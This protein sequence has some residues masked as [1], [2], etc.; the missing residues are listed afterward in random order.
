MRFYCHIHKRSFSAPTSSPIECE[1]GGHLLGSAPGD[2]DGSD[3]WEYCCD[4]QNFWLISPDGPGFEQCPVCERRTAARYFCNHCNTITVETELPQR[5][6]AVFLSLQKLPVPA[7]PGCQRSQTDHPTEHTCKAYDGSLSTL[8]NKCPFCHEAIA[9]LPAF[10]MSVS[11]FVGQSKDRLIEVNLDPDTC[12]FIRRPGGEFLLAEAI[13]PSGGD[14]LLPNHLRVETDDQLRV[15]ETAFACDEPGSGELIVVYPATVNREGEGWRLKTSGRLKVK[16]AE[17][18]PETA[19]VEPQ[20]PKSKDTPADD[21]L[22]TCAKCGIS[23]KPTYT[24]CKSCGTRVQRGNS[25][26]GSRSGPATEIPSLEADAKATKNATNLDRLVR[27]VLGVLVIVILL[28]AALWGWLGNSLTA[29]SPSN[30]PRRSE[31]NGN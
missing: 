27:L 6:R 28:T 5:G 8:R 22:I 31:R 7:C 17:T 4:C 14:I 1:K 11:E 19:P 29:P 12:L 21:S 20:K 13:G 25:S 24:F 30:S 10:P 2:P 16:T 23:L 18:V 9:V 15:Y 26:A 3:I